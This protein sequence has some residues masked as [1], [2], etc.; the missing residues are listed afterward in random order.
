MPDIAM[1]QQHQCALWMSCYRYRAVP[2]EQQSYIAREPA[3]RQE[4]GVYF[5]E[6]YYPLIF[7]QGVPVR[8]IEELQE[9]AKP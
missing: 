6:D 4:D 1:C 9:A 8:S 2:S 5:C 7:R 3:E